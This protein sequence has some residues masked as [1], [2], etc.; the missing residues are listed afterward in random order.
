MPQMAPLSWLTL[1]IIFSATLIFFCAVNY[2]LYTPIAPDSSSSQF[3]TQPF[4]WK[5]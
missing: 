2:F 1:F 5:W 4:S 3:K